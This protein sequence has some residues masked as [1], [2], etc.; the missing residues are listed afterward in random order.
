[1]DRVDIKLIGP[2]AFGCTCI[3]LNPHVYKWIEVELKLIFT[4]IYLNTCG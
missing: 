2:E 4:P 1:V 3:P